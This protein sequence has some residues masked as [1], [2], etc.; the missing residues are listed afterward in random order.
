MVRRVIIPLCCLVLFAIIAPI[1]DARRA[2]DVEDILVCATDLASKAEKPADVL[3]LG[4]SRTATA[5]DPAYLQGQL[6]QTIGSEFVVERMSQNRPIA[7]FLSMLSRDYLRQ[8]GAPTH[9]FIELMY[10]QNIV[11]ESRKSDL[12]LE[13]FPRNVMLGSGASFKDISQA[14]YYNTDIFDRNHVNIIEFYSQK[15]MNAFYHF[16]GHGQLPIPRATEACVDPAWQ[17][18]DGRWIYDILDND[19]VRTPLNDPGVDDQSLRADTEKLVPRDPDAPD[20]R[21][22]NAVLNDMIDLFIDA[23]SQSVSLVIYPI[24]GEDEISEAELAVYEALYPN[25]T[26]LYVGDFFNQSDK[27]EWINIYRDVNHMSHYGAYVTSSQFVDLIAS[28]YD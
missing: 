3:F 12:T 4:T 28:K 24:Y 25:A 26:V 17:G 20:R 15:Y 6:A 18:N 10:D 22:E 9:V 5:I 23:G 1:V 2:Y 19:R 11:A 8:R 13:F 27:S 7:V 14:E 16:I 21:Y